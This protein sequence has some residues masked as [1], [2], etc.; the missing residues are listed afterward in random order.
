MVNDH[1]QLSAGPPPLVAREP[2]ETGKRFVN[3]R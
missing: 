2:A 1:G 3:R